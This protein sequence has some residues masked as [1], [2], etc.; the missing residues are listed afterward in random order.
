MASV[1]VKSQC[2]RG[3]GVVREAGTACGSPVEDLARK[4]IN[5]Y[6]NN[7]YKEKKHKP[8]SSLIPLGVEQGDVNPEAVL[9]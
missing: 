4:G 2:G 1:G 6:K 3:T 9:A 8:L 7:N 5:E